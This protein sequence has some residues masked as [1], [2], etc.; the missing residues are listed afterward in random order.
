MS[1]TRGG[2]RRGQLPPSH[3]PLVTVEAGGDED[4]GRALSARDR[5]AA[6][7]ARACCGGA[8]DLGRLEE[9]GEDW[10]GERER[11][12]ERDWVETREGEE[13]AGREKRI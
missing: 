8:W 3:L 7:S 4:S 2:R 6:G 11:E 13:S 10:C 9:G 12:R 1:T 5:A